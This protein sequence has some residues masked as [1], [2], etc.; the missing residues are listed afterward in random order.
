MLDLGRAAVAALVLLASGTQSEA[1]SCGCATLPSE[2]L[3]EGGDGPVRVEYLA[4]PLTDQD[5]EISC[6]LQIKLSG[7]R[8]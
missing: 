1:G 7:V 4:P 2:G 6:P 8:I 3:Y 5:D